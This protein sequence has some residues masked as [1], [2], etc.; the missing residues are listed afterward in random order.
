M[1]HL[2]YSDSRYAAMH[3]SKNRHFAIERHSDCRSDGFC[4]EDEMADF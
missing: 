1:G 2:P 3:D 4:F